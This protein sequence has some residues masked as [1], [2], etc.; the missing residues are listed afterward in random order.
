MSRFVRCD[1]CDAENAVIGTLSLPPGWQKICEADLCESCSTL[2]RDFIRFKAA[3]AAKLPVEPIPEELAGPIPDK[4]FETAPEEKGEETQ[5]N[6]A[7]SAENSKAQTKS[8]RKQSL[9]VTEAVGTAPIDTT[10]AERQRTRRTKKALQGQTAI[11]PDKRADPG[12][13]V[14]P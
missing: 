11:L 5:S 14:Q 12:P 10:A 4:L 3:D 6:A 9:E 7:P 8:K 1:R 2:V 13:A